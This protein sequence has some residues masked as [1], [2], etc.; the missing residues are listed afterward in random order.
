MA[1]FLAGWPDFQHP[2]AFWGKMAG[3]LPSRAAIFLPERTSS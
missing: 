2:G 3:H 1:R